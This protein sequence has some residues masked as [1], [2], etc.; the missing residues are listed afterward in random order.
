MKNRQSKRTKKRRNK[1]VIKKTG[2]QT[3]TYGKKKLEAHFYRN[4]QKENGTRRRSRG[5]TYRSQ[6][7]GGW[8]KEKRSRKE[9]KYIYI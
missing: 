9:K 2:H 3:N 6:G 7:G 4:K 5:G 8:R 1:N